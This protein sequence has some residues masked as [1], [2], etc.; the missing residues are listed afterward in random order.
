MSIFEA[1]EQVE[2]EYYAAR[3]GAARLHG[4]AARDAAVL[5]GTGLRPRDVRDCLDR[6]ESTYVIRLFAEFEAALRRYWKWV[7]RDSRIPWIQAS[8]LLQRIGSRQSVPLDVAQEA[9]LVRQL[10]N[11]LVHL[12]QASCQMSF[13]QCRAALG[14]FLGNLDYRWLYR[15]P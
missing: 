9:D 11:S 6:L 1:I 5:H 15:L 12:G 4:A 13:E 14:K 8:L 2:R 7:R 10:R 3:T